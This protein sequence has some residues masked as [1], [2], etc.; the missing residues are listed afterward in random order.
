MSPWILAAKL[1][2]K[3]DSISTLIFRYFTGCT[4]LTTKQKIKE[5]INKLAKFFTYKALMM[6]NIHWILSIAGDSQKTFSWSG[7]SSFG[8]SAEKDFNTVKF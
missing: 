1:H 7:S 2:S 4:V 8:I 6:L 3:L 5:D